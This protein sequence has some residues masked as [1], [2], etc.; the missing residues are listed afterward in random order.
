MLARGKSPVVQ[1]ARNALKATSVAHSME[2][3]MIEAQWELNLWADCPSC[4]KNVDLLDYTDFWDCRD[5]DACENG[6]NRSN[7]VDVICPLCGHEFKVK[8]VY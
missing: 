6:T 1:A 4:T 7:D 3:N 5:L 2:V 8:C